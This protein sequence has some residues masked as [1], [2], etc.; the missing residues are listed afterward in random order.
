MPIQQLALTDRHNA[1]ALSQARKDAQNWKDQFERM[2]TLLQAQQ[3]Q[4]DNLVMTLKEYLV[5]MQSRLG[6]IRLSLP[7]IFI[8]L[9]VTVY[10]DLRRTPNG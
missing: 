8:P 3:L 4:I 9:P 7:M 10:S 2:N 6:V 1:S 5:S